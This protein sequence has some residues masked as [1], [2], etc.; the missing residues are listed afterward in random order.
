MVLRLSLVVFGH[1]GALEGVCVVGRRCL[2]RL[3]WER[4]VVVDVVVAGLSFSMV[5]ASSLRRWWRTWI[6]FVIKA[7]LPFTGVN[8]A[9]PSSEDSQ[10]EK[11]GTGDKATKD[12]R[13]VTNVRLLRKLIWK[14]RADQV[15]V[16]DSLVEYTSEIAEITAVLEKP[17]KA[18]AGETTGMFV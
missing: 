15:C 1:V 3:M 5:W 18:K 10:G 17:D 12:R 14:S 8:T 16:F 7:E 11:E 2:S 4:C 6:P 9:K 13:A